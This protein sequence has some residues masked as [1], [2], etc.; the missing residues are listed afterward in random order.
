MNCVKKKKVGS[1]LEVD[2]R[3]ELGFV[4]F[5]WASLLFLVSVY[6][7]FSECHLL[8]ISNV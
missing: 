3:G 1:N 4:F 6:V 2:S 7:C 5:Q 8:V